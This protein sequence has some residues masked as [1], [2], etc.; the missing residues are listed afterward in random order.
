MIRAI[1][2]SKRV[3]CFIN[4]SFYKIVVIQCH[5]KEAD[6]NLIPPDPDYLILTVKYYT[7]SYER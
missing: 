7:D 1:I 5:V 3:E 4:F 6:L 2:L